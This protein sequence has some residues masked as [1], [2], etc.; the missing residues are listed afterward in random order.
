MK[1]GD[2]VKVYQDPITRQ[3]YEGQARVVRMLSR[4]PCTVHEGVRFFLVAVNFPEDGPDQVVTR[5]VG[6][7][8][9]AA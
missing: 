1:P 2:V 9:G 7:P 5:T 3:D 6:E 4:K 8:E